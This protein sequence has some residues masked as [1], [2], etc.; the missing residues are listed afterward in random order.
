MDSF[1]LVKGYCFSLIYSRRQRH[2]L[3]NNRTEDAK[4]ATEDAACRNRLP[5]E[6]SVL[7]GAVMSE[8]RLDNTIFLMF[9]VSEKY[10]K[11]HGLSSAQ[12][13]ELDRKYAI[14]NYVAECPDVFD[15]MSGEEMVEE[16]DQYVSGI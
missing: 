9:M 12:F 16:I 4:R 15:H 5:A 13:L 10:K 11:S 6:I 8:K 1:W 3:S 2:L 14:L 7:E